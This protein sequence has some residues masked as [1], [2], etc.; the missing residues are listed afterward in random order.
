MT[1]FSGCPVR[2]LRIIPCLEVSDE[3]LSNMAAKLTLLETFETYYSCLSEKA[4]V[5]I[6]QNCPHLTTFKFIK[7]H[8]R[9]P[10]KD[11]D[12]E[13][14]VT[15]KHM[16]GLQHLT[17]IGNKLTNKGLKAFLDGC[18]HLESLDLRDCYNI[19]L[20]SSDLEKKCEWI[21]DMRW[22]QVATTSGSNSYDLSFDPLVVIP[23]IIRMSILFMT[24]KATPTITGISMVIRRPPTEIF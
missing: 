21:K 15:A 9:H 2:C 5:A 10:H 24:T 8:S 3:G 19:V 6:G 18:P 11:A 1:L 12:K 14:F 22:P 4:L 17:L 23:Q 20:K 16:P 7:G 13:A